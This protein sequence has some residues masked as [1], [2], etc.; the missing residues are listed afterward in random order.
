VLFVSVY[1]KYN[2]MTFVKLS[3][4]G[5]RKSSCGYAMDQKQKLEFVRNHIESYPDFPKPGI[6]F[7][8]EFHESLNLYVTSQ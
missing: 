4:Y 8:W 1:Y 3:N 5:T 2:F 6:L 7:R